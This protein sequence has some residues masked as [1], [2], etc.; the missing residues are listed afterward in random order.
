MTQALLVE[1]DYK[2]KYPNLALMKIS[3]KLK[4][5]GQLVKY[6]KGRCDLRVLFEHKYTDVY[7]TTLFTYD[8]KET[9]D[10]INFYKRM[11][12][13]A[14]IHVGGIFATLNAEY[15][16]EKTGV[17]PF[18]GYSKELD[19]LK[20]D[21]DL[22][23]TGTKWDNFSYVFTSREC[24]NKCHFCAVPILESESWVNPH[25]KD[26]VDLTRPNIMVSDNNLT[27][28]PIEH[29]ADVMSFI[30]EHNL[31]VIFDNGWDARLFNEEHL[32]HLEG[33]NLLDGGLRF[34]YDNMSQKGHIERTITACL[35]AGITPSK[36]L[37]Y[38]LFNFTDTPKEAEYRARTIINL[39]VSP[40]PQMY[41]PLD[42][43]SRRPTFIGEK[44]TSKLVKAFRFFY[45]MH[46]YSNKMTFPEWLVS[47][48][49][50]KYTGLIDDYNKWDWSP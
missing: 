44:W 1:P 32:K 14:T 20:P 28:Q 37:I 30:K 3:T 42:K 16:K 36:F 8:S 45:L 33:V 7:I 29:F 27:S 50:E 47:D 11:C 26:A 18:L 34:T 22:I 13:N 9:I 5:E 49:C 43:L 19:S 24:A 4:Q 38:T 2:T 46:G 41:T 12:P 15:V 25:W 48:K 35:N 31:R 21:Y 6:V 17:T 10:T 23:K 39:G 40:Y